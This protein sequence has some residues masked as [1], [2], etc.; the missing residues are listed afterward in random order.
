MRL[1]QLA[2]LV[3]VSTTAYAFQ[4]MNYDRLFTKKTLRVDYYHTGTKGEETFS[5]DRM[6]E[7]GDWPGSRT[8]LVDTLNLG[9]FVFRVYDMGTGAMVFSRG[10][11]SIFN[12]WQT[13][14]EA[15]RGVYKTFSE[16]VRLPYPRK[17][18]QLTIARRDKRMVFHELFSTLIDPAD[19]TQINKQSHEK[20]FLVKPLMRNGDPTQKVDIVIL[21][22]GYSRDDMQKFRNDAKR[23][24]DIMFET[25]PFKA[26]Y[27][28]FNVWTVEAESRESGIDVPDKD[29]WK[30]N[31]LGTTYNTFGSARYVLTEDNK[32]VRDIAGLAPYDFIC[33]LVNDTRYG[34]GGIYN[35]YA[36]TYTKEEVKGQEWQMD[37][38]YVHEFGHSFAGLGDEYYSSSTAYNDFYLPGIEPWEPN[39]TALT[40]KSEL[41]WKDMLTPHVVLPTPWE[42]AQYDSIEALRGKLDRL[43]SDYYEKREPFYKASMNILKT[44]RYTGM[45]GA[46]EGAGYSSKGL[47]RPAV[48]CRMFSL[49]L[50]DFDPVC[51]A[52]LKRVIDFYSK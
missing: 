17:A 28:D 16:T 26:R 30:D 24:N 44:S 39:I 27:K 31:V 50:V 3:I 34:G 48:D 10:F 38:V 42:K 13:T 37:Y 36:T 46:F 33:I 52:A 6:L 29:V 12:E 1:V 15:A 23:F 32:A 8:N 19:P 25:Q 20:R 41:K 22:D 11:S 9:E 35:L 2:L 51:S 14:D 21:G 43:A 7:E 49:S 18:I 45:V 4:G 40:N 47:Y 5:L